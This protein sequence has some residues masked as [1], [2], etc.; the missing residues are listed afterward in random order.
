MRA[1]R[2]ASR[3]SLVTCPLLVCVCERDAIAPPAPAIQVAQGAPRGELRRY[4]IGHF[5]LFHSPW[6]DRV[7]KDQITFLQRTLL[8]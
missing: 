6:F 1:D 8:A 3:V 7:A 5:D 2:P 4:P